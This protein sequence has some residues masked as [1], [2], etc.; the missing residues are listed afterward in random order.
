MLFLTNIF[1]SVFLVTVPAT[2]N[3]TEEEA[4][5]GISQD[6]NSVEYPLQRDEV[7]M[8]SNKGDRNHTPQSEYKM[9]TFHFPSSL[10]SVIILEI[11]LFDPEINNK[12]K[13]IC[14]FGQTQKKKKKQGKLSFILLPLPS[15]KK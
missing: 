9:E 6:N 8:T 12:P 11:L 7:H 4:N 14:L 5:I 10:S 2:G 3:F 1:L 13:T 15:L